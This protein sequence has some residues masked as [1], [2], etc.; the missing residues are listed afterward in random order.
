M[1]V[2]PVNFIDGRCV[3]NTAP[4]SCVFVFLIVSFE[5]YLISGVCV[6]RVLPLP[7]SMNYTLF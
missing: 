4:L 6:D 3:F 1:S 7:C 2:R 5:S